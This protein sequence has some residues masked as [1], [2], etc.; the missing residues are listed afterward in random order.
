LT[1]LLGQKT[2]LTQNKIKKKHSIFEQCD[3]YV[4]KRIKTKYDVKFFIQSCPS[5]CITKYCP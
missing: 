1:Y 3:F 2:Y 5:F 4:Y